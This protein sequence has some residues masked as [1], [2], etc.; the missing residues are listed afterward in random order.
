[1]LAIDK[2]A[3]DL[4]WREIEL[5]SLRVLLSRPDVTKA[6]KDVL[7][8]ASWALL[9]AH[10]EGFVK[11][12]LTIFYDFAQR[13]ASNCGVLPIRTRLNALDKSLKS[14]RSLPPEEF[15]SEIESFTVIKYSERPR[16]MEVDTQSNLWPATLEE[17][18]MVADI[19]IPSI[20]KHRIKLKTLV[21]RR[22]EIAHGK[23]DIIKEVG[24]YISFEN[25]VYEIM[26][27]IAFA[28]DQ[29][30]SIPPYA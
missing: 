3:D 14:I 27:D 23:Q 22:N 1:M 19:S 25:A 28:I 12:A 29:R 16:F 9:Y 26:Y 10:Y 5:A 2:I 13:S 8:R 4:G 24:Y 17:L 6:Q 7:L 11:A 21:S 20:D 18:L 15:L 30:L